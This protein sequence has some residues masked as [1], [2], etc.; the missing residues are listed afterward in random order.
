MQLEGTNGIHVS[1]TNPKTLEDSLSCIIEL[2][3]VEIKARNMPKW[4]E[5]CTELTGSTLNPRI[6]KRKT[7]ALLPT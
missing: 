6:C 4:L 1:L 2:D 3:I 5:N 7:A